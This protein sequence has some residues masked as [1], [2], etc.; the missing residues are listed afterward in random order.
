MNRAIS[1]PAENTYN[2]FVRRMSGRRESVAVQF[3]KEF[4]GT[5]L[6]IRQML[7]SIVDTIILCCCQ[8]IALRG[9]HDS[10]TDLENRGVQSNHSIFWALLNFRIAAGDPHLRDHLQRA[11]RNAS[12]KS[13]D[14]QS[15]LI[16]IL[17][18]QI[19]D[20]NLKNVRSCLLYTVIANEVTDCFNKEQLSL[21]LRYV[22]PETSF[23]RED[24]ITFLECDSGTTGEA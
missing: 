16:N 13:P 22:E 24:L 11:D 18:D 21:V 3:S 10:A 7:R 19:R 23:I 15:Q 9:H 17:C 12:Y 8:N 2:A 4:G 20:T 1:M 14:M 6:K 5:I